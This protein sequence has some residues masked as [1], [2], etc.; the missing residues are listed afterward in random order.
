M[1]L[2][3]QMKCE[4]GFEGELEDEGG[5]VTCPDCCLVQSIE[6]KE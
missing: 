2:T 3:V 1:N 4:C 5:F 6:S